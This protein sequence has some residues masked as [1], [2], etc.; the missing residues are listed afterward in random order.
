MIHFFESHPQLFIISATILLSI[1][2]LCFGWSQLKRA[3]AFYSYNWSD[4]D[5]LSTREF[6]SLLIPYFHNQ[7]Y[8]VT[9]VTDTS[10]CKVNFVLRKRGIK[11]VV[12]VKKQENNVDSLS[13]KELIEAKD[14]FGANKALLI[15]NLYYTS[16][17]KKLAATENVNLVDR[18]A[19]HSILTNKAGIDRPH[20][21]IER[22]RTFSDYPNIE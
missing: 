13:V 11:V 15:T 8:S 7:G 21:F 14:M 16:T 3:S 20:R 17:A 19:L 12:I 2:L 5:Q 22:V 1:P 10:L 4:I 6:E 18:T 9:N